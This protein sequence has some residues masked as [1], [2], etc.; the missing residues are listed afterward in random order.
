MTYQLLKSIYYTDK[1][2][3]AS[4]GR[5]TAHCRGCKSRDEK[6]E[7]QAHKLGILQKRVTELEAALGL[8]PKKIPKGDSTP[9]S[10]QGRKSNTEEENQKKQGGSKKG[11]MGGVRKKPDSKTNDGVISVEIP[12]ACPDC[13]NSLDNKGTRE[14]RVVDIEK[15]VIQ[16]IVYRIARGYCRCCNKVATGRVPAL[17]GFMIGNQLL[18]EIAVQHYIHGIPLGKILSMY[19]N[20]LGL[21]TVLGALTRIGEKLEPMV[22]VCRQFLLSSSMIQAD[23]TSWRTDGR[24]GYAWFF[25]NEYVSYYLFTHTRSGDVVEKVLGTEALQC[26]LVVDRYAAYNR[27]PCRLQYCYAHLL[28][29]V[30]AVS[31]EYIDHPQVLPFCDR[32]MDCLKSAMKLRRQVGP[33]NYPSQ[34]KAIQNEML[35]LTAEKHDHLAIQYLQR[36][37]RDNASKLYHWVQSPLVPAENNFS[38]R[39]IRTT[40]IARKNS[41]GS[42][43]EKGAKTRS[44]WM[45]ILQT[46]K[47]RT[48]GDPRDWL[49]DTLNKIA[50]NPTVDLAS[51]LPTIP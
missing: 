5:Q 23:E 22:E 37:F 12:D 9:S 43:S 3:Q 28:R 50:A 8:A 29:D 44:I 38:E 15:K 41:F 17:P 20:Q 34:A 1:E 16:D 19:G 26:V 13:G 46:A 51:L 14:R 35:L 10:Q 31:E 2:K 48:R 39:E 4:R 6:I 25:G 21:G 7:A 32:L 30:E 36:L 45:T 33:E 40:V 18:A 47:K 11:R 27:A 24:N 42:Q 49:V